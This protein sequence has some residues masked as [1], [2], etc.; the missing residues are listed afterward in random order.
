MPLG[1]GVTNHRP[2][3]CALSSSFS[4]ELDRSA[5]VLLAP[6]IADPAL[7]KRVRCATQDRRRDV[8]VFEDE[9]PGAGT[10]P[11][12]PQ[13]PAEPL[14]HTELSTAHTLWHRS[15]RTRG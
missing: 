4:M 12:R 6:E 14:D 15:T 5:K 1:E 10:N 8:S 9:R 7:G 11:G 2:L 3:A 13:G